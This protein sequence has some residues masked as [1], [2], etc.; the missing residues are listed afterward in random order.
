MRFL[1]EPLLHFVVLGAALFALFGVVGQPDAAPPH[2]I[3]VTSGK[4]RN[5]A[6]AFARTWQ[7]PPTRQELDGLV[8]DYVREEVYYRE[9]LALGLEHDDTIIRRRLRQKMEFIAD[10]VAARD[11][12]TDADLQRFLQKHA[13]DYRI[14]DRYTFRHIYLDPERHRDNLDHRA[15]RLLT[16][17]RDGGEAADVDGY[18]DPFLLPHAFRDVGAKEVVAT[19]GEQF[20]T[21][22]RHLPLRQWHGPIESAYG[23]HLV[24]V[25]EHIPGREA[26][27]AEVRDTVQRDWERERR[28]ETNEQFFQTLIAAYSIRIEDVESEAQ[29]GPPSS[30]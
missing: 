6:A 2:E 15:R 16:E 21:G 23:V 24:F 20:A 26:E 27:L 11:E 22:L 4:I 9:A 5:I 13:T 1:R 14:E 10:D 19:L 28:R 18:A 12:P 30:D 7:R 29:S 3:V 25:N 17:L 8:Q